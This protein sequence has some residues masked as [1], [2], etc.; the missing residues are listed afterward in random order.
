[1]GRTPVDERTTGLR[2]LLSSPALYEL[3][4]RSVGAARYRRSLVADHIRP[5]PGM[6]VLD[7]G[8]GPG[9]MLERLPDTDYVGFDPSPAYIDAARS[10]FGERGRFILGGVAEAA[11]ED[12]GPFDVVIAQGVLHHVDDA[13][14]GAMF[15][16]AQRV[17]RPSGRVVT[18]DP[19]LAPSQ[20][21]FAR[22][23]ILRDRGQHVRSAEGY[24]A[25]AQRCFDEVTVQERHDLL[26][27]PYSHAIV[28][29]AAT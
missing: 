24:R 10:R 12:L 3:F 26:R 20:S 15:E 28:T 9:A 29:A 17:L 11:D 6:R 1:M 19:C 23:L 4:Q 16:L 27:V 8:C 22:A 21:R 7:V 14:A 25:L 5:T 13:T 18:I 2:A